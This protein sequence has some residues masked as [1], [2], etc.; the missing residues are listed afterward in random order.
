MGLDI[1]PVVYPSAP[2]I[3]LVT[4][5]GNVDAGT[6]Y[7]YVTYVTALGETQLRASSPSNV[8]TDASHAQVTVT[9]PVSSDYRVTARRIYR[10]IAASGSSFWQGVERVATVSD[11]TTTSYTDNIA[12]AS[13]TG[14]NYFYQDNTTS[15]QVTING[16]QAAI[17]STLNTVVGSGAGATILS[18]GT[19]SNNTLF[20]LRAGDA[21]TTGS[22]VVAIGEDALG[23]NTT[24]TDNV[25]VGWE[26]AQGVTTGSSNVAIGRNAMVYNQTG[27]GGT[28]IGYFAGSGASSQS[29]YYNTGIGYT[30]LTAVTTGGYN[31]TLGAKSGAA[32]T[33]G[34]RNILLGYQ[35]GDALVSGSNNIIIGYD[36]DATSTTAYGSLNIGALIFGTG[37]DGSGTG[38]STGSIGIGTTTPWRKFSVTGTVGFDGLTTNTGAAAASLCLSST[39]E[40]TKNTDNETCLTSSLRFKENVNTLPVEKSLATL[41]ALRPVSFEYIGTPGLRYGL[42]AEEVDAID[43]TLVG[44]DKEGRPNSVRYISLVP[45]LVQGFQDLSRRVSEMPA[46]GLTALS[47]LAEK[48]TSKLAIFENLLTSTMTINS[49]GEI[50]VPAGVNEM[51][52]EG[53]LPAGQTSVFVANSK[54]ASTSQIIVTPAVALS[55]SLAVTE[56]REGEGFTLSIKTAE[57]E[58][59]PFDYLII[60]TYGRMGRTPIISP[61]TPITQNNSQTNEP[62]PTVVPPPAPDTS[63]ASIAS[64]TISVLPVV[65]PVEPETPPSPEPAVPAATTTTPVLETPPSPEPTLITPTEPPVAAPEIT[66]TP[67]LPTPVEI[68]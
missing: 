56:K 24:G 32:V 8:V 49:G 33:T 50:T 13:L 51:A 29:H 57:P 58:D 55:G 20:G 39:N 62:A 21:L 65:S 5:S 22:K 66:S 4:S 27:G 43:K 31:S 38:L 60:Q 40:V 68:P 7:Y 41:S 54:V 47:S 26:A 48:V 1:N 67:E 46:A 6:H 61:T 18:L 11:N 53:M 25:A 35:A 30:T 34:A 64:T 14:T 2:T 15:K 52:G 10:T 23:A 19:S 37:L 36:I 59:V 28:L 3:A 63:S 42:I 44:Y 17:I 45:L 12:D 9:L 16:T